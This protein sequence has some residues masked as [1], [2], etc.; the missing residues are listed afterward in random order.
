[1]AEETRPKKLHSRST[2]QKRAGTAGSVILQIF[3]VCVCSHLS[4]AVQTG[5]DDN[6]SAGE[7]SQA[8]LSLPLWGGGLA[9]PVISTQSVSLP[10]QTRLHHFDQLPCGSCHSP[11]GASGAD[12]WR[13]GVDVNHSCTSFGCHEYDETM[14]HPLGDRLPDIL[15]GQISSTRSSTVTCLSCHQPQ[16]NESFD[17]GEG[18][19]DLFL[20]DPVQVGCDSCHGMINGSIKR[21]SHWKF[22]QKAH[23][24]PLVPD[25]DKASGDLMISGIDDE[26]NTCLS[27]HDEVTATIPA[28]NETSRQKA[29]R[30]RNM[31]DHPIG[32]NY[33]SLLS[34]NPM[35]FNSLQQ[36][37]RIRMFGGQV[38]CGSC[39]S[40]YSNKPS[41]LV[42]NYQGSELCRTCHNR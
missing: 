19:P 7:F 8:D 25:S 20:Q 16:D 24:L 10:Q 33:Q 21:Q 15:S 27:C 36:R 2:L 3:L 11:A 14:N 6:V 1:M 42:Q 38:G 30:F 23:L 9:A 18:E 40:L 4:P 22:S 39:H 26:S 28:V 34:R 5:P 31:T 35:H 17:P 29:D 32:M 41:N 37:D 12:D 13:T